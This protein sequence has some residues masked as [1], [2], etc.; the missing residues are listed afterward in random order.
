M[1]PMEGYRIENSF[2]NHSWLMA[3]I[4]QTK[5]QPILREVAI[6]AVNTAAVVYYTT[7]VWFF[8]NIV[9]P[10]ELSR[11]YRTRVDIW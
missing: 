2:L 3:V 10:E 6:S 8:C 5:L 9:K 11:I 7:V 4:I 1:N